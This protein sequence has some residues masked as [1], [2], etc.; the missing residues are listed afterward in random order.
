M[1]AFLK[2]VQGFLFG[3]YAM[4][5]RECNAWGRLACRHDNCKGLLCGRS[6]QLLGQLKSHSLSFV[7]RRLYKILVILAGK[8]F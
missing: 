2:V 6:A 8:C 7:S 4:R 5:I 3:V 1:F